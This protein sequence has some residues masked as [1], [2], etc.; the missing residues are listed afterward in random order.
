MNG[1]S[2]GFS[3]KS[4]QKGDEKTALKGTKKPEKIARSKLIQVDPSS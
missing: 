3:K 2:R 4:P 1:F